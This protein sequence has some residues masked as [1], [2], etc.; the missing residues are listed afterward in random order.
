MVID[1]VFLQTLVNGLL[2]GAIYGLVALGLT[3]I[4]GVMRVINLAHGEFIILGAYT[5]FWMF[6]LYNLQPLA[7]LLIGIPL[8]FVIGMTIYIGLVKRV[9]NGPELSSL[10][11]FF[12]L[13]MI[14]QNLMLTYWTAD[15]RGLPILYS[16]INI[17]SITLVGDRLIA[18]SV[19]GILSVFLLVLLKYTYFGRAIRAV[20]QD[21]DA[22]MLMGVNVNY[23]YAM[24]MSIGIIL[25][26]LGG[27]LIALTTPFTPYQSGIYTLYSFLVVV[28][29][30]LGNPLGSL[31]GGILI[32]I[33]ESYTA[34]YWS[35]GLSPAVAFVLLILILIVKPE[36]IFSRRR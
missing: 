24:S 36:G 18:S 25:T 22:A 28:L 10:L 26:F 14:I 31:F 30:G 21:T 29:G 11:V 1:V 23:I 17:G 12:G 6:T 2:Q 3:L 9:V 16:S 35:S 7:S 33:I 19:A 32:G 27:I 4:W 15:V 5:A 8:G 20:V 34:T 13:S